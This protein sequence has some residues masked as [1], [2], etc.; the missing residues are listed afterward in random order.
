[1]GEA[2][3][4]QGQSCRIWR[5]VLSLFLLVGLDG[6]S[7]HQETEAQITQRH[8]AQA[9]EPNDE[10]IVRVRIATADI[11][12]A[13][14]TADGYLS[15]RDRSS[16]QTVHGVPL[17]LGNFGSTGTEIGA[18][19]TSGSI[20]SVASVFLQSAATVQGDVRSA[21]AVTPQ[22][23]VTI[24]GQ[25]LPQSVIPTPTEVS[26]EQ[27]LHAE[28]SQPHTVH[29]GGQLSL[30]PGGYGKLTV[31]SQGQVTLRSGTYALSGLGLRGRSI[32]GA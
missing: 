2:G 14:P 17:P 27:P 15:L 5:G 32:L 20:T 26:W 29:S 4:R 11:E 18:S 7:T 24:T 3:Q 9:A 30:P 21:G 13:T 25:T 1:M 28:P 23:S 19:V 16:I 31:N 22:A 8:Q 12:D 10:D 6:C